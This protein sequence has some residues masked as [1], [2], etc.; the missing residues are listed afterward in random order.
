M[1]QRCWESGKARRASRVSGRV[2]FI[3]D[4]VLPHSSNQQSIPRNVS[5]AEEFHVNRSICTCVHLITPHSF[6]KFLH[7][8]CMSSTVLDPVKNEQTIQL[9]FN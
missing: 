9:L 4:P 3:F 7:A 5:F 8:Y 2:V 1:I 6:N